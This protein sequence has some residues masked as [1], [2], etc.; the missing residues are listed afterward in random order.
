MNKKKYLYLALAASL[1]MCIL[2]PVNIHVKPATA[3]QL[4]T[5][6]IEDDSDFYSTTTYYYNSDLYAQAVNET[7][8]EK[9]IKS[10]S[11][12]NAAAE[13]AGVF[14]VGVI[15]TVYWE[16]TIEDG[17]I[18]N[19]LLR[20][21][22]I[23]NAEVMATSSMKLGEDSTSRGKLTIKIQVLE[24]ANYHYYA[25]GTADWKTTAIWGG[26]TYP[27]YQGMD[28]MAMTWGGNEELKMISKSVT[29]TYNN[30]H[31][32]S[33]SQTLAHAYKGYAWEF[34]EKEGGGL[35]SCMD[36]GTC[37]IELAKTYS[38]VRN[39]ET[40]V[41]FTYI[42][43]WSSIYGSLNFGI[44]Q[45]GFAAGITLTETSGQWQLQVDVPGL[46]Y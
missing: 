43:T 12:T 32:L 8:Q 1:S 24:G 25:T 10:M 26:E 27:D 37:E 13:A 45:D 19:R 7:K 21:A 14:S 20:K 22:E 35:G 40:N 3:E 44:N 2:I 18:E 11:L 31:N 33:F 34:R 6:T 36:I 41:Q 4:D 23:E 46:K 28:F 15:K 42:H 39:K 38:T 30:G 9:S 17:L 5:Y 29:G 16:E